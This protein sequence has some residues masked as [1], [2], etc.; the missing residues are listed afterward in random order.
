MTRECR[1]LVLAGVLLGF[2]G[3][4]P[5][6]AAEP[7]SRLASLPDNT[8]VDLGPY[9]CNAPA[10][11]PFR[12]ETI[13]DYSGFVYDGVNYQLLMFGGGHSATHRT[14]VAAFSFKTLTWSSAYPSTFCRDMRLSNRGLVRGDWLTSGHPIARHTYDMLVWADNVKRLL[15]LGDI[16]GQG[17]CV[18]KSPPDKE[19]Y[20][21]VGKIAMY[22]PA[23]RTWSYSP[24]NDDGW[25]D[26]AS[27]EYDPISGLVIVVDRYSVWTYDPVKQTRTKRLAYVNGA[28]G[29]AK[30]LVYFPPTRKMYYIADGAIVF[31]L[32]SR[33]NLKQ[34]SGITGDIPKLAETGFA[35][36]AVNQ[37]IGGGVSQGVFYAYDPVRKTW[38]S[39]VMK[40]LPAGERVGTVA[41][42]AHAYDPVNNVFIFITDAESGRRTW[43]YRYA[44]GRAGSGQSAPSR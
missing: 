15:L 6:L 5:S 26:F 33:L 35:Y 42:H 17:Y 39:H 41:F 44:T 32:D 13:T 19:L 25:E 23:E 2:L 28:M 22:D 20:F 27:A 29:Y 43:A 3:G 21:L 7:N 10:D 14:D 37:I 34:V 4:G 16:S 18:E 1:R 12:C 11:D 38:A 31:E 9:T 40:T 36:D 8:A 30:N 24:L